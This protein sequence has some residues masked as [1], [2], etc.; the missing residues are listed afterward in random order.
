MQAET[1]GIPPLDPMLAQLVMIFL[2]GL[3]GPRVILIVKVTQTP[4]NPLLLLLSPRWVE[5]R[6]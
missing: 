6:H 1:V 3:F 4:A 5:L 2:K